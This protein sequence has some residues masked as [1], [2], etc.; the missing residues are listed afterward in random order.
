MR[1]FIAEVLSKHWH[2]THASITASG[3]YSYYSTE[4]KTGPTLV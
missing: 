1:A 3:I 2:S 4:D